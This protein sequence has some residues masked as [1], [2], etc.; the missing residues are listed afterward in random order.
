MVFYFIKFIC[1]WL[2]GCKNINVMNSMKFALETYSFTCPY[3]FYKLIVMWYTHVDIRDFLLNSL[4]SSSG[5]NEY[6]RPYVVSSLE[7]K[8]NIVACGLCVCDMLLA[9]ISSFRHLS[10]K[11]LCTTL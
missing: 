7:W 8:C 10:L 3:S 9:K 1:W 6:T 11:Q 4:S 2:T 5:L